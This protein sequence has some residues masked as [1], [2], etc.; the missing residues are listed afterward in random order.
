MTI[1]WN[2]AF[3]GPKIEFH[4]CGHRVSKNHH[5]I[6]SYCNDSLE[7]LTVTITPVT[8]S[9][10]A[11]LSEHC[12]IYSSGHGVNQNYSRVDNS[13][14]RVKLTQ[15]WYCL[16]EVLPNKLNAILLAWAE[17]NSHIQDCYSLLRQYIPAQE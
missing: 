9:R 12:I 2:M 16:S 15:T 1:P 11:K 4:C 3:Q 6:N 8:R 5:D 10:F 13:G 7:H 17:P 14:H